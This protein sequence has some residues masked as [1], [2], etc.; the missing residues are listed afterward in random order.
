MIGDFSIKLGEAITMFVSGCEK[1]FLDEKIEVKKILRVLGTWNAN[2]S[3]TINKEYIDL[4]YNAC[5]KAEEKNE[6]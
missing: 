4:R 2:K 5:K 3:H 1:G 6:K